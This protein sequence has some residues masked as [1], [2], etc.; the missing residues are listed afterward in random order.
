METIFMKTKNGK[1]NK[2]HKCVLNLLHILGLISSEKAC[3]LFTTWKNI[4]QYYGVH[5]VF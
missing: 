2:T 3:C 4:R 5:K 1:T